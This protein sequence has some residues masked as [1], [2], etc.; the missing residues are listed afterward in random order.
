MKTSASSA[1]TKTPTIPPPLPDGDQETLPREIFR[2]LVEA[3][4]SAVVLAD[5]PGR[6]VL[7]NAG[8]EKLFGYTR[9]E[10]IGQPVE[11]LVPERFRAIHPSYRAIYARKSEARPMGKGRDLFARRKNGSEVPVEI[12]LNP[13]E[14]PKGSFILSVIIDISDRKSAEE[15]Q[16]ATLRELNDLRAALDEH[17]IVAMTDAQGT[18]VYVNDKFCEISK[19]PR[20][21]LLGQDHRLINSGYHPKEFMRNLWQTIGR[22]AVWKGEI[23]NRAK[24]GSSYWVDT[25][26]V[27]FLKEDGKPH[28]YVAIRA[29]ITERKQAEAAQAQLAA[30]VKSSEDA[31][32]GK[33]LNGIVTSWNSGAE[34]IFGYS[35]EEMVGQPIRRLIPLDRQS[36]EEGI[37]RR[38]RAGES[39]EHFAT[40]RM[41]KDGRLIDLSI[42]VS[43]I[44]DDTGRTVGASHIA[45]DITQ[46][47]RVEKKIRQLN[48]E[49]EE[50]VKQRT[51]DLETANEELE[52]FSYSVSHDLRAPLRAVDGFSQ[53]L[54]EDFAEQ[55][56]EEARHYLQTIRQSAQRM[57]ALI[58]DLLTFSR[59]SRLPLDRQPVSA[60]VLV[61]YALAELALQ[62]EGRAVEIRIA[63]LAPCEGDPALLRQVWINLLSNALKY[64]RRREHAVIEVGSRME[65]GETVYFVTDNG[66]GFDM[67]Y[68]NK[69]FG[70]FQRLHR[71]DEF[72]GTGV[73]LAIAQRVVHRHHGRIWADAEPDRGASFFFTLG[74]KGD[75]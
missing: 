36:E 32:I 15:Q 38:I 67:R 42:S 25:T 53:A 50:R 45:R 47:K 75:R 55:L 2:L 12:G 66:T 43:P 71:S 8:T 16:K 62:K 60:E 64:T 22:G 59:L 1:Q 49:L 19:Y 74:T 40:V 56:P 61:K 5:R 58:D 73:G 31:I 41:A 17:A 20:E 54:L 63:E 72:E 30:I 39:V 29:D 65:N 48:V 44:P 68:A 14:T 46:Q 33:D 6:I 13:I 4:P 51:A 70:V 34:K 24:D 21:E 37:L 28:H 7:T 52:S 23:K 10:L 57:G 27:P 18:I 69:L 3:I 9:D 35:A 26:I 11:M